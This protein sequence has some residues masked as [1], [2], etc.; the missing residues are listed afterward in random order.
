VGL[1]LKVFTSILEPK[2]SGALKARARLPIGSL[3]G[4]IRATRQFDPALTII[5]PNNAGASPARTSDDLPL[6]DV[7]TTARKRVASSFF[8]IFSLCPSRPKNRWLSCSSNG[9]SPGK[10]FS[11]DWAEDSFSML[12][13][14]M[15]TALYFGGFA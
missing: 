2:T 14:I 5:P 11:D 10:G 6:P 12:S 1:H 9:R 3:L 13:A 7:P 8:N 15:T 4:R